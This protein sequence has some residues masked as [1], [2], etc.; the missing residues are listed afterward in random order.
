MGRQKVW[1]KIL[2]A[3]REKLEQMKGKRNDQQGKRGRKRQGRKNRGMGRRRWDGKD[4]RPIQQVI[5]NFRDKN[6]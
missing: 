5:G 6:P 4:G 2:G 1:W 3:T